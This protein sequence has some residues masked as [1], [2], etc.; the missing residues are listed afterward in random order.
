MSLRDQKS[1]LSNIHPFELLTD[2]QINLCIRH[3][4]IAYYAKD[5][6]L[7]SQEKV[8]NHFFVIIK[9]IVHEHHEDEIFM[10]Y[11]YQDSFDANSLIYGK[12]K[13]IF[14]VY[15]DLICYEI[16]KDIFLQLIEKND[17]F[18]NF[19]LNNLVNKFQTLKDKEYASELSS[20]MIAK[21]SDTIL[22]PP[23]LVKKGTKL[24]DAIDKSMQYK[25]STI[26]VDYDNNKYGIITD[27]L[28]KV[29][30][31]L[32]GRDL[33]IAVEEIAITPILTVNLDDYLFEALTLLIKKSIKRVGVINSKNEVIGILEQIDVL[34]HFANHTYVVDSK[35]KMQKI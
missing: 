2:E 17:G 1:F 12:T 21:V 29:K 7:I 20:F 15:E 30:V 10:D 11:H 31:L 6:V 23:C 4:D 22:N 24:I 26:I 18:K 19:F 3:M 9:G 14:K 8:P 34:S 13:N 5:E 33:N 25:T 28:L 27:S 35:I 32:E 16:E